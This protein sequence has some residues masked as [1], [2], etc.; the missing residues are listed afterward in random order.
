MMQYTMVKEKVAWFKAHRD[1]IISDI[2]HVKRPTAQA[3]D[4]FLHVR[5]DPSSH[6]PRLPPSQ[7]L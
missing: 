2:V 1:I 6:I 7:T 3:M 5:R 4:A